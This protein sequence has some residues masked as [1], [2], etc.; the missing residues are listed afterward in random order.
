METQCWLKHLEES[1]KI[2][3]EEALEYLTNPEKTQNVILEIAAAH[4]EH[5]DQLMIFIQNVRRWSP[6]L[7]MSIATNDKNR[8]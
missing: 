4:D 6:H 5:I 8:R 2:D 7:T 3:R 1:R